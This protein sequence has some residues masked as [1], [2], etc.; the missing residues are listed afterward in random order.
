[1]SAAA[2]TPVASNHPTPPDTPHELGPGPNK[3]TNRTKPTKRRCDGDAGD[4]ADAAPAKVVRDDCAARDG[5]AALRADNIKQSLMANAGKAADTA[6]TTYAIGNAAAAA[7]AFSTT[8]IP[9]ATASTASDAESTVTPT[10]VDTACKTTH[11]KPDAISG[12]VIAGGAA[13]Q[14]RTTNTYRIPE[15]SIRAVFAKAVDK[16]F[17]THDLEEAQTDGVAFITNDTEVPMVL[18]TD[19]RIADFVKYQAATGKWYSDGSAHLPLGMAKAFMS[20]VKGLLTSVA[21]DQ[22]AS[23]LAKTTDVLAKDQRTE[24]QWHDAL[25][26]HFGIHRHAQR[27]ALGVAQPGSGHCGRVQVVLGAAGQP[28]VL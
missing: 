16:C 23:V 2:P 20:F 15:E 25:R 12:T 19:A 22:K 5:S 24:P 4:A 14:T 10:A 1:M 8:T 21:D 7:Y 27:I 18:I 26:L 13:K 11:A 9:T 3:P 28:T 6:P 17:A